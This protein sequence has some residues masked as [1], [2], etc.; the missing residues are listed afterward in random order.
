MPDMFV[1]DIVPNE[2]LP[3]PPYWKTIYIGGG[4]KDK[5]N[6]VDV[7]GFLHKI[8]GL[9]STDIGMITV[10]DHSTLVANNRFEAEEVVPQIRD[11]K[12]KGKKFKIGFAR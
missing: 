4:K 3:E 9:K 2:P 11:Q 6:K 7:V 12:I 10:M 5:I 8:G 1:Y